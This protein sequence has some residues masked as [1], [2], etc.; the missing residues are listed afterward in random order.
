MLGIA[1][2]EERNPQQK[3]NGQTLPKLGMGHRLALMRGAIDPLYFHTKTRPMLYDLCRND[4]ETVHELMLDNLKRHGRAIRVLSAPFFRPPENLMI[5]FMG[6]R[7]APFGTA[8]GLDKNADAVEALSSIFPIQENGT[9]IIPPRDGN[10]KVRVAAY[11]EE[12]DLFNAQGFP[13]KGVTY[14]ANNI[15]QYRSRGGDGILWANICGL[16][17]SENNAVGVAMEEMKNLML[18]LNNY[19][20]G[21]VWNPFSPNTAALKL[22]REPKVFYET[23]KLMAEMA[24]GKLRLVKIGP[25]EADDTIRALSLVEAF[26]VGRGHGVVTTNT[27]L[28][29]K[30]DLPDSIK[31][32]WGYQSAGRSGSF[33]KT[34]R[35]R[36]VSDIRESFPGSVIVATGGIFTPDDAYFS[37][38]AGANV[39]EGYTPYTYF[40]VGLLRKIM[41]GVSK[42]LEAEHI[43]LEQ[44]QKE[45]AD[46]AKSR[47]GR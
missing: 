27:K 30:E 45:V 20:D 23:S 33:L 19:V 34:Y 10:P 8:A 44:L 31:A 28:V 17:L 22:L 41:D 13:S 14:G 11:Q 38:R 37:F 40:G 4:P 12:L 47:S 9:F 36:S 16:P 39:L 5:N 6:R 25:Y 32:S 15:L 24:P 26:M 43:T 7:L 2:L 3:Q 42:R 46:E 18:I 1:E 21:F 35:L 29:A